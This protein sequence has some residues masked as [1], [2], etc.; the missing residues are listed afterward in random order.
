MSGMNEKREANV[1]KML[2]SFRYRGI[3]VFIR[4]WYNC[5]EFIFSMNGK[6]YTDYYD[7]AMPKKKDDREFMKSEVIRRL[8]SIA[9]NTIDNERSVL[10]Q[11][12]KHIYA[13]IQ[14][15][16]NE[17]YRYLEQ[18]KSEYTAYWTKE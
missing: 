5:Y 12:I 18:K 8:S 2:Q 15:K 7:V 11:H 10:K 6:V 9:I 13:T 14:E 4:Q 16:S 3:E 1:C 17:W